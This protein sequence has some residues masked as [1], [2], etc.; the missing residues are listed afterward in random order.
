M[1]KFD[2]TSILATAEKLT[3]KF[4]RAI[5]LVR[6]SETPADADEPWN[7]PTTTETTVALE[8]VFVPPNT[9]RQFGLTALGLG[10]ELQDL[11]TFSEQIIITYPGAVDPREYTIVRDDSM[12]WGIVGIQQLTPGPDPVLAFIGVRR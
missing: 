7:G 5:T 3:Y 2:Y 1:E 8:G 11:V 10:T 4:G 9:V 12:D 6:L